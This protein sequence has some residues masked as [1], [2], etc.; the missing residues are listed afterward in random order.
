MHCSS[1]EQKGSKTAESKRN[2][3]VALAVGH[4]EVKRFGV[5]NV[6]RSSFLFAVIKQQRRTMLHG[7]WPWDDRQDE[8]LARA[9]EARPT[10]TTVGPFYLQEVSVFA[11]QEAL[12]HAA[13]PRGV[14]GQKS[15]AKVRETLLHD[16]VAGVDGQAQTLQKTRTH[17]Q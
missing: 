14:L 3:H 13:H 10:K 11:V 9:F 1:D 5:Y 17:P 6:K 8:T 2:G 4:A 15:A 16:G 7:K 12:E